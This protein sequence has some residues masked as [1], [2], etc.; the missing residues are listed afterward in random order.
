MECVC[1]CGKERGFE[2]GAKE[3]PNLYIFVISLSLSYT[4]THTHTR[5]GSLPI[6]INFVVYWFGRRVDDICGRSPNPHIIVHR[7][8]VEELRKL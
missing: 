5:T 3:K 6:P 8:R 4:H 1:V 2:N 7:C